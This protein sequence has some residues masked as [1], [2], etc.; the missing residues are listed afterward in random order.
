MSYNDLIQWLKMDTWPSYQKAFWWLIRNDRPA[1]ENDIMISNLIH[2]YPGGQRRGVT[3]RAIDTTMERLGFSIPAEAR[4]FYRETDGLVVHERRLLLHDFETAINYAKA[5]AGSDFTDY[6]GLLP[7]TESND[8]NPYCM[9]CK[10]PIGNRIVH[11][12]HDD[13]PRLA[14]RN[15]DH[16]AAAVLNLA[17]RSNWTIDDLTLGYAD[18]HSDRTAEDDATADAII[19]YVRSGQDEDDH[20]LLFALAFLSRNGANQI[21][22]YLEHESMW[23][24]EEAAV[25]LGNIGD[26]IAIE[27][28]RSLA[29]SQ[30]HR[31]DGRAAQ[32]AIRKLNLIKLN[33]HED[34]DNNQKREAQESPRD[35]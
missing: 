35:Q 4:A 15:L 18:D 2:A 17:S 23:V 10:A 24:R 30:A 13:A 34:N 1:C 5:I 7:L 16:F 22:G 8:S 21:I 28:L 27:A 33:S 20:L 19:D 26:T 6:L 11:L 32:L 12:R 29:G 25:C 31:Q 9:A 3:D 14:F